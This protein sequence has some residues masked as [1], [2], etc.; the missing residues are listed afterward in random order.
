MNQTP[1]N[2]STE[3]LQPDEKIESIEITGKELLLFE[4]MPVVFSAARQAQPIDKISVPVTVITAEDIHYS[5][6]T[7]IPDILQF[8]P[9][10]DYVPLSRN[11]WAIG[12]RGLH[13]FISDRTLTLINGRIADGPLFGGSEFYRLP[14]MPED[15]DRIEIVRGPGG[16]AWGANAFTGVINII[17]KKPENVQGWFASNTINEF[18]DNYSHIRWASMAGPLSWRIS[19]GYS[20]NENSD[21]AGAGDY[22]SNNIPLNPLIG[23]SGY[24]ARDFSRNLIFDGEAACSLSDDT[25]LQFGLGY[26]HNE[27]GDFEFGGY[28]PRK[29]TWLETARPY[30]K[31]T[32]E[33]EDDSTGYMQWFGNFLS[34]QFPTLY[35]GRFSENDL[36]AQWNLRL[37]EHQ[38]SV[39]GNVRIIYLNLD[40]GRTP[41]DLMYSG[42]PYSE[43][44]AGMFLIDRWQIYDKLTLEGQIRGDW[45]SETQTDWSS[46]LTAIYPI[47]E[48]KNHNF[49]IS[50]AKAFRAPL[51]TLRET[52]T[53]RISLAPMGLPGLNA[54]NVVPAD[55]LD[56]EET[57]SL[58]AG[59]AGKITE[60]LNIR[61]DGYYQ[62]FS[63]LIGYSRLADPMAPALNR[64]FYQAN[65]IDGA[66][67]YGGEIEIERKIQF[68]KISVWYAYND[69]QED[70]S[71]QNVRS[72]APARHKAG[73]TGR[74]FISDSWTLNANYRYV[75][76]THPLVNDTLLDVSTTHRLDLTI[77]KKIAQGAG[78][79]MIGVSD[80]FN[81]TEGPNWGMGQ[82]TA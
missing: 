74:I 59:Y 26:S 39:G 14:I 55:D 1:E 79:F 44:L 13:D 28:Y 76:V 52:M 27:I 7:S 32:H 40:D 63:K 66:D 60:D 68:G 49:R 9:G 64:A 15:I 45:Y 2:A 73:M 72:Y 69:F 35:K 38:L 12:V 54:F 41:Q 19:L 42:E 22:A 43:Q 62:R 23:F 57:W 46:R 11:R 56:N 82:I 33:F 8:A 67:T 16:A 25:Q 36:E 5:G 20:H 65:N 6:L 18:G 51:A 58:E 17:T 61:I 4:E 70:I 10:I 50:W 34:T 47:D 30:L 71:H 24:T 29:N 48:R 21:D 37:D 81:K 53:S 3:I 75:N 80:L 31:V 78:E 77:M